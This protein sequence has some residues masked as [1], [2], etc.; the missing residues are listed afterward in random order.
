MSTYHRYMSVQRNVHHSANTP[1]IISVNKVIQ[2]QPYQIQH[3][4]QNQNKL[5]KQNVIPVG[6]E[7]DIHERELKHAIEESIRYEELRLQEEA[8]IKKAI[9][10]STIKV[11]TT[12]TSSI[13]KY[14]ETL[15]D[16]LDKQ[17]DFIVGRG[18]IYLPGCLNIPLNPKF[19]E[20]KF[21]TIDPTVDMEAD[22]M[23]LIQDVDFNVF[24]ITKHHDP[25]EIIEVKIFF[26]WSSFYC[27]AMQE[28]TNI[29]QRIGRK[30]KIYVPL[31]KDEN[32]IPDDIKRNLSSDI[33]TLNL[34]E[35]Q[36]PLF[37]WNNFAGLNEYVN[38]TR[39]IRIDAYDRCI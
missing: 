7:L 13:D 33:F 4:N 31:S 29:I 28:L 11:I 23:K 2:N 21:I 27:G 5:I 14:I 15:C 22:E 39:Y 32:V 16:N 12:R 10:N 34:V 35:G 3:Q 26:D 30:C 36:Y 6:T 9:D 19:N 17:I 38:P 37:D 20:R 1:K 18:K 24:G 25:D 8:N